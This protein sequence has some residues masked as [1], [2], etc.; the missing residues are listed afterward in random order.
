MTATEV[1][2]TAADVGRVLALRHIREAQRQLAAL[3]VTVNAYASDDDF[4]Q[5][6]AVTEAMHE[7][8]L[9]IDALKETPR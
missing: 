2:T 9:A 3:N 1:Y 7:L 8:A 5:P 4:G 6:N